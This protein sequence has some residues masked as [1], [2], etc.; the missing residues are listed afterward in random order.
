MTCCCSLRLLY[1]VHAI[2]LNLQSQLPY[3]FGY[4]PSDFL[5]KV[6]AVEGVS[7]YSQ[8]FLI[9][10]N[11]QQNKTATNGHVFTVTYKPS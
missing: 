3:L 2:E 7:A 9:K 1:K 10:K 4:K 6:E 5:G 8:V 11:S